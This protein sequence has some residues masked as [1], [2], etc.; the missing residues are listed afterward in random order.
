[1]YVP[2]N[3]QRRRKSAILCCMTDEGPRL[4]KLDRQVTFEGG[5]GAS[6]RLARIGGG[7][8][9]TPEHVSHTEGLQNLSRMSRIISGH[10]RLT[11]VDEGGLVSK[12]RCKIDC[13]LCMLNEVAC[14][15]SVVDKVNVVGHIL[16]AQGHRHRGHT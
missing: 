16:L 5:I 11:V 15:I 7:A 12:V 3:L 9:M 8:N 1:M 10:E 13:Q 14:Y 4:A 2:I 6:V